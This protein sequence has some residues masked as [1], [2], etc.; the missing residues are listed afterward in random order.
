MT[1]NELVEKFN[2]QF[3]VGSTVGWRSIDSD[4]MPHRDYTVQFAA[5]NHHGQPVA[6][7]KERTGMVSI[8]PRFVDYKG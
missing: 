4:K 8:E 1:V 6:W 2:E 7:F 5:V 3:P